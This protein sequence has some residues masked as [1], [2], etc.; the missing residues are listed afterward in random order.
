MWKLAPGLILFAAGTPR[1]HGSLVVC[2]REAGFRVQEASTGEQVLQRLRD[3]PDLVILGAGLPDMSRPE[4]CRRIKGE[5]D[6]AAVLV[7]HLG[8]ADDPLPEGLADGYLGDPVGPH[9]LL[10]HVRVLLRLGWAEGALLASEARLRDILDSAPIVATVKDLEGRY[11][12][13]NRRW[14]TLFHLRREQI[15]GK[16]VHDVHPRERADALRAN[17]LRVMQAGTP[18]EF[19]EVLLQDD[20]LHTYL[21]VK[22]ALVDARGQ[23]YAVCGISTDI[24]AR[25]RAEEA[26]RDSE[27]LYHSLV[28]SL[29][30]CLLHKDLHGRFTFANRAFCAALRRSL[31]EVIGK[32]DADFYPGELAAKYVVDDR[33]VLETCTVLEAIEEHQDPEGANTYVQVLKAPL[34]NARG[35]VIG[36]QAI[37]WDITSRRRAE[38]ELGRTA[39]EFRVA[40]RIQQKLFPGV[41]PRLPGMDIAVA[42][43]GFD[44]GGASYPAEAIGG[45]YYDFVPLGDGSLGIAI[46]DV[47]G[48]GVGPALL[49]AEV[50]AFLRAF[51]QAGAEVG[52]ILGLVN[53]VLIPD[54]ED[55]RFVTLLLARLDPRARRFSYTSAGHQPGYILDAAGGVKHT[56]ASTGTPL[57][58]FPENTFPASAEVPLQPGDL[59]LL[60]TDGVADAR[61][62]D[63]TSF[64]VARTIDLVRSY[65]RAPAREIVENIYH[66]VRAF[67]QNLPQYDDITA[68]VVKV[69]DTDDR[70]E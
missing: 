25:K 27:A 31:P 61:A 43:Y 29:P 30:V 23:P 35:E 46:G 60:V 70:P 4:V 56:L 38:V 62:P 13:V 68:T 1:G 20:V 17:D 47:S 45:D 41:I 58:I 63:G 51:A 65:R 64:G 49:M 21:S 59:I 7:L 24:T 11:Q 50:R 44:I 19:E 55:D 40:R 6:T 2:L 32:T 67:A 36:V 5:P 39:A 26:V 54:V 53:R 57:G 16:T 42:S 10:T 52:A 48:H 69:A 22:F 9:E 37:Y 28:E 66:G 3:R 18:L 8:D 14:E 15:L 12:L 34:Q 33:Q